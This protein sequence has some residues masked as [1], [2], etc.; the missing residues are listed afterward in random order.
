MDQDIKDLNMRLDQFYKE[1]FQ[2]NQEILKLQKENEEKHMIAHQEIMDKVS[3]LSE[4]VAP[5]V[6]LSRNVQGFDKISVW[7][8]KF[9][10]G[11]AAI[12]TA[13]GTII[14]F[15]RKVLNG[16]L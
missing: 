14:Y 2:Q 6:K 9:L 3:A 4:E 16:D 10:L 13:L 5:V 8:F 1:T 15:L 7:I 11:I 12:I